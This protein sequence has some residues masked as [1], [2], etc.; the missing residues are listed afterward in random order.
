MIFISW[1][2]IDI[3]SNLTVKTA[4]DSISTILSYIL[5]LSIPDEGYYRNVSCA[6]NM[7]STFL[8]ARPF[9]DVT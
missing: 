1:F 9:M 8:L 6:L 4:F 7:I 2:S 3:Y 5:T